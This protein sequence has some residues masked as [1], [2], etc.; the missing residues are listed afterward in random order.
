MR[1]VFKVYQNLR[2]NLSHKQRFIKILFYQYVVASYTCVLFIRLLSKNDAFEKQLQIK[3]DELSKEKRKHNTNKPEINS[4]KKEI[5]AH[6]E[7]LKGEK[8]MEC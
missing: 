5:H 6:K 3:E 7:T 8:T 2:P 4:L 1:C